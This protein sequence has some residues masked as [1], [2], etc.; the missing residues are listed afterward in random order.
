MLPEHVISILFY[1]LMGKINFIISI[2]IGCIYGKGLFYHFPHTF[3]L[4][5]PNG[6]MV[7]LD[8]F[9]YDSLILFASFVIRRFPI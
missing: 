9:L 5:L 6:L 3:I 2:L 8:H 4:I 1:F 7:H